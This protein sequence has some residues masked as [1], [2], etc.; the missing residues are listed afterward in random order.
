VGDLAL[1]DGPVRSVALLPGRVALGG[2]G[3]LQHRLVRVDGDGASV[4][5]CGARRAERAG[6]APGAERCPAAAAGGGDDDDAD[7]WVSRFAAAF[8]GAQHMA[9]GVDGT[10]GCTAPPASYLEAGFRLEC[11]TVMT[12]TAVRPP[13]H[14][15][16]AAQYR[17]LETEDDWRRRSNC[18]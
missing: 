4:P 17:P 10:G 5:R 14:R 8:P 2:A 12:A 11:S 1:D 16:E 9:I 7:R 18:G 13:P 3:A 15:N 6:G